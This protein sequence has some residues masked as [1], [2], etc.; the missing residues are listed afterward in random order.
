MR[1]YYLN[2]SA[3]KYFEG[4][5]DDTYS[6]LNVHDLLMDDKGYLIE[7]YHSGDGL[8]IN[9][10]AYNV[11]LGAVAQNKVK[12]NPEYVHVTPS[13]PYVQPQPEETTVAKETTAQKTTVPPETTTEEITVAPETTTPE[14]TTA[15]TQETT[16]ESS[17]RPIAVTVAN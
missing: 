8:H 1:I 13:F 12:A 10:K 16:S 15:Q 5:N 17:E 3:Q 4:L 7:D 9:P 6:F 11:V 2:E 14:T